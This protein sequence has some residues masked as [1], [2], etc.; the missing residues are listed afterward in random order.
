MLQI[1]GIPDTVFVSDIRIG[2]RSVFDS[3]LELSS[4]SEPLQV[5]IDATTGATVEA[6]VRTADGRL[7][8]R[9]TVVLVPSEDRR[10]NPMRYK[11]GTTD[12]EGRLIVRGVAPGSYTAFVWE[13][14]QDTAWQNAEFL[15]KYQEQGTAISVAPGAQVNLQLKWIPFDADLR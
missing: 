15:S 5:V 6:T 12:N 11:T 10:Q 14:V 4:P 13:S 8:P 2:N 1:S 9:A 7:A 3:G